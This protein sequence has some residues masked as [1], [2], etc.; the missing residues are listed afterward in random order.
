[1]TAPRTILWQ[2]L[3]RGAAEPIYQAIVHALAADIAGGRLHPGDRLPTHRQLAKALDVG[4]GTVTRAYKE[5]EKCGLLS[6]RVG[7]GT[8]VATPSAGNPLGLP[9][10]G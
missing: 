7:S 8:F 6:S 9:T 10:S 2:P 5:A 3:V 1:M 4:L